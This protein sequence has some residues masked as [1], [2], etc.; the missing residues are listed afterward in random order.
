M[1]YVIDDQGYSDDRVVINRTCLEQILSE[2]E[3][4]CL[5]YRQESKGFRKSEIAN[6]VDVTR[7]NINHILAKAEEL[8]ES[9]VELI[10]RY[11]TSR[12]GLVKRSSTYYHYETAKAKYIQKG[13]LVLLT[14]RPQPFE[15]TVREGRTKA[16][17]YEFYMGS[18]I[19][20]T[21]E[22]S[23]LREGFQRQ[24]PQL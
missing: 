2:R 10:V 24:Q 8:L 1:P 15:V 23:V 4:L 17:M 7:D 21:R 20:I 5:D 18:G 22:S 14:D 9:T 19:W 12:L 13:K 6:L 11:E 16:W 3:I